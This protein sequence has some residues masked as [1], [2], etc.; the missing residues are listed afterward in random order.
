MDLYRI[1]RGDPA[2]RQRVAGWLDGLDGISDATREAVVTAWVSSWVSSPFEALEDM[3]Y[4][5]IAPSYRLMDHVNEVTRAG[6]DLARRAARDWGRHTDPEV[7]VP[8]LVLHDIDKPLLMMREEGV[9]RGSPLHAELP[10]GVLGAMMLRELGFPHLVV[11][12]V[13]T[14][15]TNAP[16]HGSTTEAWL[17]H[18]ADLFATD[19]ALM[20]TGGKPFYQRH[21]A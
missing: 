10:H 14:H 18:Y 16:F 20:S 11:S 5:L 19:H 4:S 17:L 1:E 12:T 9:V 2:R 13:A 15:A 21:W 7:L 3:P 6:L 8:I